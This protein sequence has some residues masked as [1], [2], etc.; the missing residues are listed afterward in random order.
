MQKNKKIV[1]EMKINLQPTFQCKRM[2]E[3]SHSVNILTKFGNLQSLQK[4]VLHLCQ[5]QNYQSP[6]QVQRQRSLS[7]MSEVLKARG[8]NFVSKA[9]LFHFAAQLLFASLAHQK[10]FQTVLQKWLN[11]L[12]LHLRCCLACDGNYSFPGLWQS[13]PWS[14]NG[15]Y[16][17]SIQ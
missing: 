8:D 3:E 14:L 17:V 12:L 15:Q 11:S 1:Q 4:I 2:T 9:G 6:A 16:P 5:A 13:F 10:C 7:I